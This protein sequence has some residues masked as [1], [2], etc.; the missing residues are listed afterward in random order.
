VGVRVALVVSVLLALGAACE[1]GDPS[2]TTL[3]PSPSSTVTAEPT[4]ASPAPTPTPT[5]PAPTLPAAARADTPAGAEAFARFY[6][7]AQDYAN[8]SGHTR[9]LRSL[10]SCKGC[11][12]VAAGIEKFYREGGRVEG[13]E[14][15]VTRSAIVRYVPSKAVLISVEYDQ[16]AGSLIDA[17]GRT[18]ITPAKPR[19]R[20]L[21]TLAR[22]SD[23]WILMNIQG[24]TER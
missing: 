17:D 23:S 20:L 12:A 6:L 8:R 7:A 10:G 5:P 15:E 1:G 11:E 2:P 9:L 4:A 13:G 18:Q 3:P 16:A 21:M 24:V 14:I 19:N 22:R